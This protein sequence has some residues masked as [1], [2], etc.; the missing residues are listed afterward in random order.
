MDEY[1][2]V[3]VDFF[4]RSGGRWAPPHHTKYSL[5]ILHIRGAKCAG[6]GPR[7]LGQGHMDERPALI[8]FHFA[9]GK[10]KA[11]YSTTFSY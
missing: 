2:L 6:M 3:L 8:N 10:T 11:A 4:F 9:N 5:Y 1:P 7:S